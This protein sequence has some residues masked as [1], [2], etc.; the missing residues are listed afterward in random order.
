MGLHLVIDN[1]RENSPAWNSGLRPMDCIVSVHDWMI[2]LMDKA[3][4]GYCSVKL[5]LTIKISLRW[6]CPCFKLAVTL[7]SSAF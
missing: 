3:E 4:V 6:P 2:T 1:I 5:N 7:P